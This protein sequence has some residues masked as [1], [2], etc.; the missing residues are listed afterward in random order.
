MTSEVSHCDVHGPSTSL[1]HILGA[2]TSI[3]IMHRHQVIQE[4]RAPA[5]PPSAAK[6][7]IEMTPSVTLEGRKRGATAPVRAREG[8]TGRCST[9]RVRQ[10]TPRQTSA[11]GFAAT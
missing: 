2:T 7:Q 5:G 3:E 11:S 9:V 1:E 8:R 4:K 6:K 10:N